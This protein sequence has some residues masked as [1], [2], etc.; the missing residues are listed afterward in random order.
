MSEEIPSK[1]LN[2]KLSNEQFL[3]KMREERYAVVQQEIDELK[4]RLSEKEEEL[5]ELKRKLK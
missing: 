4:R 1:K 2:S 5:A 3:V